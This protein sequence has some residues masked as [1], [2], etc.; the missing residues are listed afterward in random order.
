MQDKGY[1]I[2]N[3]IRINAR[4][5]VNPAKKVILSN[6]PPIIQHVFFEKELKQI[7]GL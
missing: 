2:L 6:A 3:D 1:I 7:T 4:R 5:P